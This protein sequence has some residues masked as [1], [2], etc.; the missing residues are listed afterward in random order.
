VAFVNVAWDGGV[1]GFLLDTTVTPEYRR[2]GIGTELVRRATET[3][4]RAELEWLHVDHAPHLES[5]YGGCLW[6]GAFS[7]R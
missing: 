7:G 5:F 3:A 6:I 2:R 4:R 1:R